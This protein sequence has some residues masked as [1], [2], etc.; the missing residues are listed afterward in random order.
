MNLS[1]GLGRR[2]AAQG[3][4]AH[5]QV[6]GHVTSGLPRAP[7]QQQQ[8]NVSCNVATGPR[9]IAGG[10]PKAVQIN[11]RDEGFDGEQRRARGRAQGMPVWRAQWVRLCMTGPAHSPCTLGACTHQ[12]RAAGGCRAAG[13]GLHTRAR[14]H[15]VARLQRPQSAQCRQQQWARGVSVLA[16]HHSCM[17]CAAA[18]PGLPQHVLARQLA[19]SGARMCDS[20]VL[21]HAA[22]SPGRCRVCA[23]LRA[24]V[25]SWRAGGEH[26][27]AVWL[28]RVCVAGAVCV[29]ARA[30]HTQTHPAALPARAHPLCWPPPPPT[31]PNPPPPPPPARP[32]Q[33]PVHVDQP[34][35]AARR[36]GRRR[37]PRQ[38]QGRL[39]RARGA[40]PERAQRGRQGDQR[41]QQDGV[42]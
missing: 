37:G 13:R 12:P 22:R 18:A 36:A 19:R 35:A 5:R 26:I 16:Q 42:L 34:G 32:R 31:T 14:A 8:R 30:T 17:Q 25:S 40:V 9:P 6:V 38:G 2:A 7:V 24:H 20:M 39:H 21:Q 23:C 41:G 1:T 27:A 28:T 33:G 10:A 15:P 29:R 4:A 11:L 3:G